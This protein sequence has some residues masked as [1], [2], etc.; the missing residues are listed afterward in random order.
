LEYKDYYKILGVDKNATADQIK[1]AYRK[2]AMKYHPDKTKGDKAAEEKFKE[3]NEA[4]EVLSNAE[5][6]KKYDELGEN[7]KYYQQSGGNA[8]DFDWSQ[9]AQ[10]GRGQGGRTTYTYQGDPNDM[11]GGGGDFSDFFESVFGGGGFGGMGGG[12]RG[13]HTG[14][15]SN[16]AYQGNDMTAGLEI[17]LQEAYTGTEKVFNLEGQTIKLK[18]KPGI[19]DG[20]V[21]KMTGK[22]GPGMNGGPSGNLLITVNILRDSVFERKGDDLYANLDVDVYIAVLGGKVDFKTLKGTI[23]VNIP[24]GTQSG[25]TLK[26]QGLGMPDYNNPMNAGNLF[27]KINIRVPENLSEKEIKLFEELKSLRKS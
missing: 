7:W 20:H 11:F 18:I 6:R 10:G 15:R 5:N 21:L 16:R 12:T 8:Q 25:K 27:L 19:K 13:R 14:G 26:L 24:K 9:Y 22:G 23:K 2:L 4:N 17:T 3:I 1:S